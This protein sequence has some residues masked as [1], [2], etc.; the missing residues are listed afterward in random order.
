MS[1]LVRQK[2][3]DRLT[4]DDPRRRLVVAPLL[5]P[6]EQISELQASIDIRLG[7]DFRLASA[8]NIGVLDEFVEASVN[9]F[10]DLSRVYQH[11]YVPL[12]AAVTI[13][14]HQLIL[15]LTLEYLR[16]PDDLMAYV[17]GRSS[18][19]RLG[20]IIATAM[21]IHPNFF[22]PLTL[23]LRNLG[24][25]PLRL[26][27]GQAIAQLFFHELDPAQA[28]GPLWPDVKGRAKRDYISNDPIPRRISSSKTAE[29][30]RK[31]RHK[32]ISAQA[33]LRG[34]D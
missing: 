4:E 10:G 7:C 32:Q 29:R 20:L 16:L 14:P 6:A 2:L 24:E 8:S 27:P 33:K 19:G 22:G 23:E 17:V 26:Y 12:G 5:E 30:L 9:H 28:A 18:F 3:L 21:G 11:V 1:V 25:A 34:T 31:L 13:H 15:A